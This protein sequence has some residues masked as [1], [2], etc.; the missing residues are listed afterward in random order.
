MIGNIIKE[1][2]KNQRLSQSELAELTGL[3]Q[4]G[5]SKLELGVC[6]PSLRTM[7]KI[8]KVLGIQ[9]KIF[10]QKE[11]IIENEIE[12]EIEKNIEI[13]LETK[14]DAKL[15]NKLNDL[16]TEVENKLENKLEIK[17]SEIKNDLLNNLRK[18]IKFEFNERFDPILQMLT[19]NLSCET[20]NAKQ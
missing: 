13:R 11:N 19:R 8:N 20:C 12:N 3:T 14:L 9:N 17:L 1:A 5:I 2:R 18:E 15:G 16:K 10:E 4:T 6:D 7:K